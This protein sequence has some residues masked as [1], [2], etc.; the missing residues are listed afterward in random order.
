MLRIHFWKKSNFSASGFNRDSVVCVTWHGQ[1]VPTLNLFLIIIITINNTNNNYLLINAVVPFE[2]VSL[3]VHTTMA[4]L[5]KALCECTAWNSA[6]TP[7]NFS[8]ITM[9]LLS[10]LPF[11]GTM[12]FGKRKNSYSIKSGEYRWC[13]TTVI[14]FLARNSRTGKAVWAG[15]LPWFK[16]QICCSPLLRLVLPNMFPQMPQYVSVITLAY[17]VL[18][19]QIH[20]AQLH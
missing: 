8:W 16:I 6:N 7:C 13:G 10:L 18:V 11:N 3:G 4:P 14:L 19:K 1:I 5:F 9:I 17:S 15:A 12:S 20:D 2:V